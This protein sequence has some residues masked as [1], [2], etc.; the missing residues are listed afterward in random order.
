MI[1]IIYMWCTL[2]AADFDININWGQFVLDSLVAVIRPRIKISV[3]T[4]ILVLGFYGYIGDISVFINYSKFKYIFNLYIKISL[5]IYE[6]KT[7]HFLSYS[8]GFLQFFIII[9]DINY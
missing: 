1:K 5:K 4:D 7:F 9:N 3:F 8:L 2:I 6:M